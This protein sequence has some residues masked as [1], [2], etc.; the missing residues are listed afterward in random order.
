MKSK[1]YWFFV[2]RAL[3]VNLIMHVDINPF[4]SVVIISVDCVSSDFLIMSE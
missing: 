3:M 2:H 1:S 4:Q